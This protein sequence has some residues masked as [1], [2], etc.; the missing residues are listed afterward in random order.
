MYFYLYDTVTR[1]RKFAREIA[2]IEQRLQTLG[3][4]GRS[5]KLTVLKSMKDAVDG[6]LKRGVDSVI[7]I[8]NDGSFSKVIAHAADRDILLG[9]I[10]VGSGSR[11][12]SLLGIPGG[13]NACDILS[14]RIVER[15]D[16]GKANA[17]FFLSFLELEQ[18]KDLVLEFDQSFRAEGLDGAHRI[19]LYNIS[20]Y[21]K[22][23]D[24]MLEACIAP[25]VESG[26]RRMFQRGRTG[27]GASVIPFRSLRVKSAGASVTARADGQTVVKTPL[28]VAVAPKKL[29]VIVGKNR[30]FRAV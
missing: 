30:A 28:T 13:A 20:K 27:G 10:P 19:T 6:A 15:L 9:Y 1:D 14:G 25:A 11:L 17:T 29:R 3:I 8:G 4:G 24:G 18:S 26:S 23:T 22:P 7:V 21:G 2:R 12:A 16:V 5:E